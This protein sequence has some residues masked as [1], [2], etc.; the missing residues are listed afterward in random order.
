MAIDT[1]AAPTIAEDHALR[2][3]IHE[4][5]AELWRWRKWDREHLWAE[6][7]TRRAERAVELRALVRLAR[8]ARAQAEKAATRVGAEAAA[9]SSRA[10]AD[11]GY[12]DAQAAYR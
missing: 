1:T 10:Y 4:R 9:T 6:W 2:V 5:I 12:H 3:L 7:T 11:L 8:A